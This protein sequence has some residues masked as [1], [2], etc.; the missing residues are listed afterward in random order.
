MKEI[1]SQRRLTS[2]AEINKHIL[3]NANLSTVVG[4]RLSLVGLIRRLFL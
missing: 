3:A 1:T 4:P 2:N